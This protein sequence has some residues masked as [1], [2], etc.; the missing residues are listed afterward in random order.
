ME[1]NNNTNKSNEEKK[2]F[3][4]K[5]EPGGFTFEH[6]DLARIT[7][8]FVKGLSAGPDF[9]EKGLLYADYMKQTAKSYHKATSM[10]YDLTI[11]Q[12]EN[13]WH[14]LYYGLASMV[15]RDYERALTAFSAAI[16]ADRENPIAYY[17][18]AK[19][20]FYLGDL[21]EALE[22][23]RMACT[24]SENCKTTTKYRNFLEFIEKEAGKDNSLGYLIG[25]GG[26]RT[27]K[28]K[29]EEQKGIRD[30]GWVLIDWKHRLKI[31][32][33]DF[34]RRYVSPFRCPDEIFYTEH[35]VSME[36]YSRVVQVYWHRNGLKEAIGFTNG[37][38]TKTDAFFEHEVWIKR[39]HL[40]YW[41]RSLSPTPMFLEG[42]SEEE[43]HSE[44]NRDITA[45]SVIAEQGEK[46]EQISTEGTG[47]DKQEQP[48]SAMATPLIHDP[49]KILRIKASRSLKQ[50]REKWLR[51]N[52]EY[53][54]NLDDHLGLERLIAGSQGIVQTFFV[55]GALII[56]LDPDW[57]TLKDCRRFVAF[58]NESFHCRF[59][60][61]TQFITTPLTIP[62]GEKLLESLE[63]CERMFFEKKF[64]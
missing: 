29:Y 59:R 45:E 17:A 38:Y 33:G 12:P 23:A 60:M 34:L 8:L 51:M 37:E 20:R 64:E 50:A 63:Q 4:E 1:Q 16:I 21:T 25:G 55:E 27:L 46:P 58:F 39:E 28:E 14:H 47:P 5:M 54:A 62:D 52:R 41:K 61:I 15:D 30:E 3:T 57:C 24:C 22:D 32:P 26:G 36:P 13:P 49:E 53:P 48:A 10:F 43:Y 11:K 31:K 9:V 2:D 42:I 40:T 7:N 6:G 18:R 56:T 35:E 44:W 19:V